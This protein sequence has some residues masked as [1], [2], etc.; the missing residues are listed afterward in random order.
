MV[1]TGTVR[2]RCLRFV[3]TLCWLGQLAGDGYW[4]G[5]LSRRGREAAVVKAMREGKSRM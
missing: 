3:V 2:P 5:P 1:C 4:I